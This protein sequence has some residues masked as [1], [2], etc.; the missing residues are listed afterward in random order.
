LRKPGDTWTPIRQANGPARIQAFAYDASVDRMVAYSGATGSEETWLLDIR[1]GTWSRSGAETPKI[2][3]PWGMGVGPPVMVYDEAAERTGAFGM[4]LAAYDATADRWEILAEADPGGSLPIP[5]VYD[6]V[7]R[8]LV[9]LG[10]GGIVD[11]GGVVAFDLVT[12]TWTELLAS[13]TPSP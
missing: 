6:P 7:N 12:R 1:T 11:R 5:M 2:N 13:S 10:R 4:R 3:I 9:G 8:R